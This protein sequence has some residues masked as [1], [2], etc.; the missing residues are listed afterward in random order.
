MFKSVIISIIA[1]GALWMLNSSSVQAQST[2][3]AAQQKQVADELK[4][5]SADLNLS[6]SQ[7]DQLRPI[8][9]DQMSQT[10]AVRGDASLSKSDKSTKIQSI[11]AAERSKVAAVLSPEQMTKWDA[12]MAKANAATRTKSK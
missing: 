9:E 12:E 2:L 11:R 4:R 6:N 5:F 1:S 7:R 3:T 10:Q 8:L